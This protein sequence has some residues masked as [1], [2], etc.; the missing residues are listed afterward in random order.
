MSTERGIAASVPINDTY[1]WI[2]GGSYASQFG[3]WSYLS[4]SEFLNFEGISMRGPTLPIALSWHAMI[5]IKNHFSMIVGGTVKNVVNGI[6]KTSENVQTF[7]YNHKREV[8]CVAIEI[9]HIPVYVVNW[10]FSRPPNR[11]KSIGFLLTCYHY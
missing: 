9:Q 10:P 4:S 6:E 7:Y 2:T 3:K 8:R 11:Y 5:N 1:L